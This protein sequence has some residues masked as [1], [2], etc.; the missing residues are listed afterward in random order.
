MN[1]R[2]SSNTLTLG[3]VTLLCFLLCGA[4]ALKSANTTDQRSAHRLLVNQLYHGSSAILAASGHLLHERASLEHLKQ[5]NDN[6]IA[7]YQA[8]N[9]GNLKQGL[10]PVSTFSDAF[11]QLTQAFDRFS[12]TVSNL[13]NNRSQL[14]RVKGE[15]QTYFQTLDLLIERANGITQGLNQ[16]QPSIEHVRSASDTLIILQRYQNSLTRGFEQTSSVQPLD[17]I[18]LR[19]NLALLST[20]SNAPKS[21]AI[22]RSSANLLGGIEEFAQTSENLNQYHQFKVELEHQLQDLEKQTRDLHITLDTLGSDLESNNGLMLYS[23]LIFA[24]LGMICAGFPGA[25]MAPQTQ[26][27]ATPA[28][29]PAPLEDKTSQTELARF[30][31]EK[32]LLIND[33]KPL[34]DGVLYIK[35]D[36]HLTTTSELARCLNQS[37]EAL[38]RRIAMLQ[39]NALAVQN[40]LVARPDTEADST[41]KPRT[42]I[43]TKPVEELTLKA[44]AE[45][46]GLQRKLRQL[47]Y[48]DKE[49]LKALIIRAARAERILDE[50]RVRVR[51]GWIEELIEEQNVESAH[52]ANTKTNQVQSLVSEMVANLNEFK[53]EKPTSHRKRR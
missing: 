2:L 27:P 18:S 41:N 43:N 38:I 51:K 9:Q 44:N 15:T 49:E 12:K 16:I 22:R 19:E 6:N 29:E 4:L 23:A 7:A 53:L 26:S 20:A 24:L 1:L 50:I 52:N 31:T 30:K 5:L 48:S 25:A 17:L 10:D 32:N 45:L 8:L 13:L 28:A 42:T 36:E 14:E 34:A 37:R 21:S 3:L 11:P 46:D 39:E 47:N 40:Q 33:I 35:A